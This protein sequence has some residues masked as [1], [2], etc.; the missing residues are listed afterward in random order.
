MFSTVIAAVAAERTADYEHDA[1]VER[2]A[3]ESG[4]RRGAGRRRIARRQGHAGQAQLS[5]TCPGTTATTAI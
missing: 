1:A 5:A 2:R 4:V 3:R